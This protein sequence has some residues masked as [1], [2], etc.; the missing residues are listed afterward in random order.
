LSRVLKPNGT[1][2]ITVPYN[3]TLKLILAAII[4]FD[5]YFDPYSP[6]IRFFK[7]SSIK[8][9]LNDAGLKD[10]KVGYFGRFFPLSNGMYILAEKS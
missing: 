1:L 7:E 4:D 10:Q 3:G 6:H 2:V 9:C 5:F 8:K